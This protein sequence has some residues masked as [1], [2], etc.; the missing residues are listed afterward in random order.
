VGGVGIV[1]R[2]MAKQKRFGWNLLVFSPESRRGKGSSVPMRP[3]SLN[4]IL[5][6]V[7]RMGKRKKNR[8]KSNSL[9]GK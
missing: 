7:E 5:L 3:G 4:R 2:R 1:H 6:D 9:S 8:R